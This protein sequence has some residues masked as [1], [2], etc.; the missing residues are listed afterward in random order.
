MC[1]TRNAFPL[2]SFVFP[3]SCLFLACFLSAHDPFFGAF[4][5]T[6]LRISGCFGVLISLVSRMRIT[7]PRFFYCLQMREVLPGWLADSERA[8]LRKIAEYEQATKRLQE[9]KQ[10]ADMVYEKEKKL[11]DLLKGMHVSSCCFCFCFYS[12]VV[13]RSIAESR[14]L[15]WKIA[16]C[17]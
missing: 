9:R 16:Q 8:K 4:M 17:A 5:N 10:E 12:T 6:M 11:Q 13:F 15:L 7:D 14:G 2:V 1:W 3:V